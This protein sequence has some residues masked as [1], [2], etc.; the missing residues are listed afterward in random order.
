[1]KSGGVGREVVYVDVGPGGA[2]GGDGH[3]VYRRD[4]DVG[5]RGAMQG[6][7]VDGIG[8]CYVEAGA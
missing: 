1:M 4:V 5:S 8:A 3:A 6:E 2:V 7:G